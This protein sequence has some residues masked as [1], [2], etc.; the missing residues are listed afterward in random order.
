MRY[1]TKEFPS[2]ND[3]VYIKIV[4]ITKDNFVTAKLIEY[5]GV[6]GLLIPS[7]ISKKYVNIKKL[8]SPDKIYACL[9][10]NV[11]KDKKY[12]DLSYKR[13]TVEERLRYDNDY[14]FIEKIVN[15]GHTIKEILSV[16]TLEDGYGEIVFE[17]IIRPIFSNNNSDYESVY[18]SLLEFPKTIF[19]Y[20]T[21]MSE[22]DIDKATSDISSKIIIS[23]ISLSKEFK[24]RVV[25][26]KAIQKIKKILTENITTDISIEYVSSST[27]RIISTDKDKTCAENKINNCLK[28]LEDNCKKYNSVIEINKDTI[29]A[30]AKK[31]YLTL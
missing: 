15:L 7:E 13:I 30:K 4:N 23:E 10:T 21:T 28:I 27:F 8:F 11:D 16:S 5:D 19:K 14:I 17:N 20:N 24:L 9:A 31:V 6:E 26:D 1:Y 22:T 3:V 12:A 2:S 18:N 29:V 25:T